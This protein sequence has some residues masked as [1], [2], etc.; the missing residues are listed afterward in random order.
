MTTYW[1]NVYKNHTTVGVGYVYRTEQ[2]AQVC[3]SGGG[4]TITVEVPDPPHIWKIGDWFRYPTEGSP[5]RY[6]LIVAPYSHEHWYVVVFGPNRS[7]Q[8]LEEWDLTY[9]EALP[10]DPPQ[11]FTDLNEAS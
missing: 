9:M 4:V 10:C 2:D 3:L 8:V 7:A 5:S 1:A 11:W 6:H